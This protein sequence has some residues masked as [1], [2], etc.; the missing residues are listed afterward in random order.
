M[1]IL[2]CVASHTKTFMNICHTVKLN[3]FGSTRIRWLRQ[4]LIS[5]QVSKFKC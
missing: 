3:H 5:T 1:V 4:T 2:V